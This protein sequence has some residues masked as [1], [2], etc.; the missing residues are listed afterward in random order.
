[1]NKILYPFDFR[2]YLLDDETF[3]VLGFNEYWDDSSSLSGTRTL[4]IAG[5]RY[6]I[7][8]FGSCSDAT[9]GYGYGEPERNPH[10][11]TSSDWS[12][13]YFL[14]E[15]YEDML[16]KLSSAAIE[17]FVEKT[18][19]HGVNLYPFIKSWLEYKQK[20]SQDATMLVIQ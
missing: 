17:L 7:H 13:L 10:Y 2:E 3:D 11:F 18:K 15:L 9:G 16:L 14:H 12:P 4:H 20:K 1:M 5:E 6:E 19:E 8:D